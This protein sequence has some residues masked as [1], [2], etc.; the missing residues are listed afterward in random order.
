V[1]LGASGLLEFAG[2]RFLAAEWVGLAILFAAGFVQA[3]AEIAVLLFHLGQA[4]D[5]TMFL[6]LERPVP[7]VQHG[8]APA[9]VQQLPITSLAPKTRGTT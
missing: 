6:A 2:L 7:F 3:L 8:Q 5:Q 9:E 4:A 1:S